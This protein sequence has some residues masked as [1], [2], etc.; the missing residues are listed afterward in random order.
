MTVWQLAEGKE[1]AEE[2]VKSN[3]G[4]THGVYIVYIVCTSS[5]ME[6]NKLTDSTVY[7]EEQNPKQLRHC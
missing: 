6:L 4:Q 7:I 3:G 1:G 2:V 5:V